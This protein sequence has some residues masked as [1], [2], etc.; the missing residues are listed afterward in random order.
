M[1]STKVAILLATVVMTLS[2]CAQLPRPDLTPSGRF[3]QV[4]HPMSGT[5]FM[6]MTFPTTEGCGYFLTMMDGDKDTK[7]LLPFSK[8]AAV[9]SSSTL[10]Y[11]AVLRNKPYQF[12][13]E[14]ETT[15]MTDCS[16]QV[17]SS[18][19]GSNKENIEIIAPCKKK[20]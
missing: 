14:I 4:K 18:V 12:M 17:D 1:K 8:C 11:R 13:L 10:D 6:Q 2:G 9:S 20:S 7:G 15:S 19:A 3:L 16:Q 5:V